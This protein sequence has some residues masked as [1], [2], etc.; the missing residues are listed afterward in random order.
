MPVTEETLWAQVAG[1]P[2]AFC[3]LLAQ[4][5]STTAPSPTMESRRSCYC[6]TSHRHPHH[7]TPRSPASQVWWRERPGCHCEDPHAK[8]PKATSLPGAKTGHAQGCQHGCRYPSKAAIL[9]LL[10]PK[11]PSSTR[12]PVKSATWLTPLH[13]HQGSLPQDLYWSG[14]DIAYK[15]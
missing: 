2:N 4:T 3:S 13:L 6:N 12:K 11:P 15:A 10:Q 7:P 1:F 5:P 14:A 8:S 9:V